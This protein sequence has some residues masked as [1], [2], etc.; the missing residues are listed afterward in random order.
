MTSNCNN[1]VK[2]VLEAV[3]GQ[4]NF[5]NEIVWCYTGPAKTKKWFPRKHDV[6]F[7]YAKSAGS[8]WH[9]SRVTVPYKMIG[10]GK[11]DTIF[12]KGDDRKRERSHRIGGPTTTLRTYPRGGRN[13]LVIPPKSLLRCLNASSRPAATGTP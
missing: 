2:V 12:K 13:A 5:R 8:A 6:I 10:I 3:F 4:R 1:R 11:G 9:G 7:F